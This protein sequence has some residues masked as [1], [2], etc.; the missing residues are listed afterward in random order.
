M[1]LDAP[2]DPPASTIPSTSQPEQQVPNL[3][4]TFTPG[5]TPAGALQ[6]GSFGEAGTQFGSSV[7]QSPSASLRVSSPD[8]DGLELLPEVQATGRS[9]GSRRPFQ[10][11]RRTRA[12]DACRS[13]KTKCDTPNQGP[14][15][16]CQAASLICK[17]SEGGED[18]RRHGPARRVR[19][20]E[21]IIS[22]LNKK[23][24]EAEARLA[25]T[26]LS[27]TA[28]PSI[29]SNQ[30]SS[31]A[32]N[33]PRQFIKTSESPTTGSSTQVGALGP[34]LPTPVLARSFEGIGPP[35][36][37]TPTST[38]R[39]D[40][41]S[42]T[43]VPGSASSEG[44]RGGYTVDSRRPSFAFSAGSSVASGLP[45]F[46]DRNDKPSG[47][48][49]TW[50]HH[51]FGPGSGPSYV[52]SYTEYLQQ[53]GFTPPRVDRGMV[54][55][56]APRLSLGPESMQHNYP[57]ID[58]RGFL[59]PKKLAD[60][61]LEIFRTTIQNYTPMFY[62]PNLTR[63]F[64]RAWSD[65]IFDG[66]AESVRSIFSVVMM[67]LA[68]SSQLLEPQELDISE[69]EG[70]DWGNI[71]ER[72]GWNFYELAR[73]YW[74]V[75][76]PS[77][78]LDDGIYLCLVAFY[79]DKACLPSPCWMITGS[80]AR[81]CQDL[82]LHRQPPPNH[83]SREEMESRTRLFWAVY[84]QDRKLSIKQGRPAIFRDRDIDV[85]FP[86]ELD[87]TKIHEEKSKDR[88]EIDVKGMG[89]RGHVL[90]TDT[91][92]QNTITHGSLRVFRATI[93]VARACELIKDLRLHHEDGNE[94]K[95]MLA[96]ID[97]RLREG[98]EAFPE[99]FI[100]LQRA[101]FLD[102]PALRPLLY[103]QHSRLIL[104]RYFTDFSH[105]IPVKR[106]FRTF[107]LGQS[108]QISKITAHLL[109]RAS[110]NENFDKCFGLRTDELV[111][112]HTFRAAT[113]LLL[114]H[115]SRDPTF[116]MVNKEEVD[117]CVRALRSVAAS[118][119][120]GQK[121]L[122]LFDEFAR[123]FE[124]HFGEVSDPNVPPLHMPLHLVPQEGEGEEQGGP[125]VVQHV[126][127]E[128]SQRHPPAAA[129]PG[130]SAG[131]GALYAHYQIPP[132]APPQWTHQ[133]PAIGQQPRNMPAAPG[134]AAQTS[135][136]Q[137]RYVPPVNAMPRQHLGFAM[138]GVT[139]GEQGPVP[140]DWDAFQQVL[141]FDP[142]FEAFMLGPQDWNIGHQ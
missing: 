114:G 106:K 94:D 76:N 101:D 123:M 6:G 112:V 64:E 33:T 127:W 51:I 120:S 65:P 9:A 1:N 98:W 39:P 4:T 73:K 82:G 48:T 96:Q 129:T 57:P 78:T 84:T 79:L 75:N 17:F 5:R 36:P 29:H 93:I 74:N 90:N 139:M 107:C 63:K 56:A 24:A 13:R 113:I 81:V 28:P 3:P 115:Y 87:E 10:R 137:E 131:E 70:G 95:A 117:I 22:G 27:S 119:Q 49:I 109:T 118:H 126:A 125:P 34:P 35:P 116:L 20:L 37:S 42:P 104:Y 44:I 110:Q 80:A 21:S 124:Y 105:T 86:G 68:V 19:E 50:D 99:E 67:V 141:Q 136:P 100:D 128:Q 69:G 66:D 7:A 14:C 40:I 108:I 102:I 97:N 142:N 134:E 16:A 85:G 46:H 71:Q 15:A 103:L 45:R 23:L 62:W 122:H 30:A 138:P 43:A 133:A 53:L 32:S 11:R 47:E 61:L 91:L 135:H 111:H 130:S 88:K 41:W 121:L 38:S 140:I 52:A 72:N 58:L 26:H 92:S 83:F 55:A 59:P 60:K 77:Y 8:D 25:A 31:P 54:E 18:R 89:D 2:N 132:N 12:C